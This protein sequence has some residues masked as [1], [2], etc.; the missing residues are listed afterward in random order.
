MFLEM[1]LQY[2]E[3]HVIIIR[4]EINTPCLDY[5]A[6]MQY[7]VPED[8]S[9]P[10]DSRGITHQQRINGSLHFYVSA[11]HKTIHVVL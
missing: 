3:G 7:P 1:E 4:P 2:E 6:S 10:L 11:I 5:G 9:M 8:T